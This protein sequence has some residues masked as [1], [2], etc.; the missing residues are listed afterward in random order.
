MHFA[1]VVLCVPSVSPAPSAV[2]FCGCSVTHPTIRPVGLSQSEALNPEPHMRS[3]PIAVA[4]VILSAAT[5]SAQN[6]K[7]RS[8]NEPVDGDE[9]CKAVWAEYGRTMSGDPVA[10]YCEIRDVGTR[11]A[12]SMISVDGGPR[13]GVMVRGE[14]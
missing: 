8:Y 10:V 9:T 7:H 12:P 2:C 14:G 6:Y 13:A 11:P 3:H 1:V 4:L 5:L